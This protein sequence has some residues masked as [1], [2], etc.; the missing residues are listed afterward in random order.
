MKKYNILIV[1]TMKFDPNSGGVQRSTYKM[2]R[3]FYE[4]GCHVTILSLKSGFENE[5]YEF[6][7]VLYLPDNKMKTHHN[8]KYVET[9]IK[10][11]GIDII[12]NQLGLRLNITRFLFKNKSKNIKLI[13]VYR[14]NPFSFLQNY[15]ETISFS[16]NNN[17][18]TNPV[19]LLGI[20]YY[21]ILKHKIY[22]PLLFSYID[23][24]VMLSKKFES[25]LRYFYPRYPNK[26]VDYIP[27]PFYVNNDV[28]LNKKENMLLFVGRL[29]F[30][31]KRA[32]ILPEIWY[33]L[34][35]KLPDW[36]FCIVGDGIAKSYLEN[37]KKEYGLPRFEIEGKKDPIPYYQKAKIFCMTSAYEGFGNVL[38]EAQSHGVVPIAFNSYSA[39][40]DILNH[41]YDSYYVKPFNIEEYVSYILKLAKDEE[42]LSIKAHNSLENSKRFDINHIGKKW[43]KMFD[44]LKLRN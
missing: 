10:N 18:F 44:E 39:L 15:K 26:K 22:Y 7:E 33:E 29:D 12:I 42:D 31:H 13:N 9:I 35:A 6:G 16:K 34:Y 24:F 27:N 32:D 21:H 1:L 38:V 20:K 28:D 43:F 19:S 3:H 4:K 40:S 36:K 30:S 5:K 17:L 25:E 2:A 41:D 8:N 23:K 37:K 14:S 11:K